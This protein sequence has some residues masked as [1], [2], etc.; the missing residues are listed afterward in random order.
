MSQ[1]LYDWV[2]QYYGSLHQ[3]APGLGVTARLTLQRNP[4][5]IAIEQNE[6][7]EAKVR[8]Y[9]NG[10]RQTCHIGT[11]EQT[12]LPDNSAT[13]VYGEAMLTMQSAKQKDNI[14]SEASAF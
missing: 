7:A 1:H 5:Y 10:A 9:L 4:H 11:A 13:I 14:I 2:Y 6:E 12:G 3:F 8:S